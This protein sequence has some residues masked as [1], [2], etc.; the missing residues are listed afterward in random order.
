MDTE[1]IFGAV[2]SLSQQRK[3]VP[4]RSYDIDLDVGHRLETGSVHSTTSC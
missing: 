2:R 3:A 1:T 4:I